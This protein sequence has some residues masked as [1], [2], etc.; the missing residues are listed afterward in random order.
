MGKASRRRREALKNFSKLN[1]H[2]RTGGIFLPPLMKMPKLQFSSWH[3]ERLPEMAWAVLLISSL[4]RQAG[5][6]IFRR[7]AK[8]IDDLE[9]SEKIH[10]VTF[11][12]LEKLPEARREAFIALIANDEPAKLAMS[13]LLVLEDFPGRASWERYLDSSIPREKAWQALAKGVLLT[14]DHQSQESTDCRWM[15]VLAMLLAGKLKLPAREAVSE[16]L[17]YPTVGDMRKVRPSIRAT[18]ISFPMETSEWP[19]KFW[20]QCMLKTPCSSMTWTYEEAPRS[21]PALTPEGIATAWLNLRSHFHSSIMTTAPDARHDTAFGM[22]FYAL[23]LA[24]DILRGNIE[25]SISG[26]L[27]LRTLVECNITLAYLL[28]L[29]DPAVWKSFRAYGAGQAK[30]AFLKS[31]ESGNPAASVDV[32]RLER[33]ANEDVW[34]EFLPINVGHWEGS[35][36]RDMSIKAGVK[37]IYDRFYS[38]TSNFSHGH[39]AAVRESV[40]DTCANPLHRLHRVPRASLNVLPSVSTDAAEIIDGI[41]ELVLQAYPG[42]RITLAAEASG[43]SRGEVTGKNQPRSGV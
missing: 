42:V 31:E 10:D 11:S 38:W 3:A 19:A 34:M 15:R 14:L 5:L 41:L 32:A 18:E 13:P 36:L 16:F 23:A 9:A 7:A 35:N 40:F 30:L 29:D 43:P 4:D 21:R 33:L 6:D 8:F 25:D 27:A 28:K 26:R 39:W 24:G 1:Q 22:G 37:A 12:G 20:E 17:D 2:E